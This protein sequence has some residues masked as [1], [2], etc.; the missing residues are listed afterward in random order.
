MGIIYKITN[1]ANDKVYV[2][3]TSMLLKYR[4]SAHCSPSSGCTYMSNAIKKYGK[5]SFIIEEI[6]GANSQ[7]ELNYLEKHYIISSNSLVPNGYNLKEGGMN[8]HNKETINKMSKPVIDIKT[9]QIWKTTRDCVKDV[10]M[11]YSQLRSMLAG[12]NPNNTNL[13]YVGEE[14]RVKLHK[15][16]S[17][18]KRIINTKTGVTYKNLIE[19]SA[20]EDINPGTLSRYLRGKL[21][22]KTHLR[23]EDGSGV[24]I[25]HDSKNIKYKKVIDTKTGKVFNS[26][27]A[28][29]KYIGKQASALSQCLNG[30]TENKTSLVF[31]NEDK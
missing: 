16:E 28:A 5:E 14:N 30:I 23:Y 25:K 13:R 4:W 6:G 22:N 15:N 17:Y 19:A 20:K 27:T 29:S 10:G 9:R 31:Y 8:R 12:V 24:Y 11:N 21:P 18:G 3:Q 2:G 7:D 1:T 26:I